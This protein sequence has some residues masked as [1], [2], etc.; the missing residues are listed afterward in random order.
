MS[1]QPYFE[2]RPEEGGSWFYTSKAVEEFVEA[3]KELVPPRNRRWDGERKAWWIDEEY[4]DE[5]RELALEHFEE[6]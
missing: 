1:S 4:L 2:E 5:A 6:G 3:L